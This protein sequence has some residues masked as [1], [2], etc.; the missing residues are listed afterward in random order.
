M[1]QLYY[2]PMEVPEKIRIKSSCFNIDVE[3]LAWESDGKPIH[4][5]DLFDLAKSRAFESVEVYLTSHNESYVKDSKKA[6]VG[7]FITGWVSL[8]NIGNG[9]GYLE[10]KYC[11]KRLSEEK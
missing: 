6:V 8:L 1:K 9:G 3:Y 4:M 2:N 7:T 5:D 11:I 10:D